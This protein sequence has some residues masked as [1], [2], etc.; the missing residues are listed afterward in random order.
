MELDHFLSILD[1]NERVRLLSRSSRK[2]KGRPCKPRE[3]ITA[4]AGDLLKLSGCKCVCAGEVFAQLKR[5][6]RQK[7]YILINIIIF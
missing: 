7:P 2:Y 3:V 5:D 6:K 1:K 4:T